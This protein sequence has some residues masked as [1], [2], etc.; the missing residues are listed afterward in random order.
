MVK[1]LLAKVR[2]KFPLSAAEVGENDMLNSAEFGFCSVGTDSAQLEQLAVNCR[3]YMEREFPVE[4]FHEEI[5][6]EVF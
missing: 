6:V 1:S 4:F 5:S 3:S 2:Q